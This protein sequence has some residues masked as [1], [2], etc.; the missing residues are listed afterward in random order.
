MEGAPGLAGTAMTLSPSHHDRDSCRSSPGKEPKEPRDASPH[1][2][3]NDST[4]PPDPNGAEARTDPVREVRRSRTSNPRARLPRLSSTGEVPRSGRV[5]LAHAVAPHAPPNPRPQA[6][7]EEEE[8]EGDDVD[9]SGGVPRDDT[10]PVPLADLAPVLRPDAHLPGVL[11]LDVPGLRLDGPCHRTCCNPN[12]TREWLRKYDPKP[13]PRLL[14]PMFPGGEPTVVFGVEEAAAAAAGLEPCPDAR[15]MWVKYGGIHNNG[16]KAAFKTAGFRALADKK[17]DGFNAAWNGALKHED[18]K[19]LN[20]YQRVNHFPGTWELGR[21]DRLG[22]NVSKMRRKHPEVFDIQPKSFVLPHDADEWRLECERNPDGMYIIKP[23]ASSRGRGIKMYRRPSDVKPEKDTLI[24]R[25]IRDPHLIDG[26]KYDM[27]VYVAVTCVDP[28]RVYVYKEGLVRLATERYTDA[29]KDLKRRCMHLTNYSV[30]SK[31]EGF[32]MGEDASEDDVGFKWS[33]SALRRHF[34]ETGVDYD[35]VWAKIKDIVVK[36]LM[37]AESKM[38]TL[39]KMHVPDRRIC[40]ELFGF[41]IML[42][43]SHQPWLIEV[44][45]GP[46]LSAPSSLDMHIKHRMVA[47]LFNLVGV[48]PYDRAEHKTAA[49]ARRRARLTGVPVPGSARARSAPGTQTASRWTKAGAAATLASTAGGNDRAGS[50]R[51]PGAGAGVGSSIRRSFPAKRDVR[52]LDGVDFHD[53]ALEDL[54]EVIRDA[55]AELSRAGAFE[56]CFPASD[57]DDNEYYLRHFDAPRFDNVLLCKWEA[58]KRAVARGAR[59][60][61]GS[62]GGSR[63]GSRSGSRGGSRSGSRGDSRA[64]SRGGGESNGAGE[65]SRACSGP[66]SSR[67]RPASL[68]G[69]GGRRARPPTTPAAMN[70]DELASSLSRRARLDA[71]GSSSSSPGVTRTTFVTTMVTTAGTSRGGAAGGGGSARPPSLATMGVRGNGVRVPASVLE[72]ARAPVGERT[73]EAREPRF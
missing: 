37:C 57:P 43:A 8:T 61:D 68:P 30:N 65:P 52:L 18:F 32:T 53:F 73:R 50:A 55:E 31:T 11:R 6:E 33:L 15:K 42:D 63:G 46:S 58:H 29:G 22:R 59:A 7:E 24:Q 5:P 14:P 49:A 72:R 41:D 26:Y 39:V 47:N 9:T 19:R 44:N 12:A 66:T 71:S 34:D 1:S 17:S 21:K 69:G 27:R 35:V 48:V 38:N 60:S 54:P 13:T 70:V 4:E 36:T 2:V 20:R 28:L 45:T 64:G 10:P 56:R 40:Y 62:R 16:V 23:P 25:Y 3:L 67:G 51:R